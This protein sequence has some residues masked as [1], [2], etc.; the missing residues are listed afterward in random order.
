MQFAIIPLKF[1]KLDRPN[2]CILPKNLVF[3]FVYLWSA[4]CDLVAGT[5]SLQF[6]KFLTG[7]SFCS[8]RCSRGSSCY[9]LLGSESGT[10]KTRKKKSLW[11][12]PLLLRCT[13]PQFLSFTIN[14]LI[15]KRWYLFD[16]ISKRRLSTSLF[17]K[18]DHR[19]TNLLANLGKD[20]DW[21]SNRS[22]CSSI[23]FGTSHWMC[24]QYCMMCYK[25]DYYSIHLHIQNYNR[26]S[27]LFIFTHQ[28]NSLT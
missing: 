24:K 10:S 20:T 27:H 13:N 1:L 21:V 23:H 8:K 22:D 12:R 26:K 15:L 16:L 18:T 3:T 25:D 5:T 9:S 4:V 28:Y 7:G 11:H 14:D 2:L 6:S 19:C 17:S